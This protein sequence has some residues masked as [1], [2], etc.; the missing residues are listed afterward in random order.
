MSRNVFLVR[1]VIR[2][3]RGYTVPLFFTSAHAAIVPSWYADLSI[4]PTA[5]PSNI[6]RLME[7]RVSWRNT[8]K[9]GKGHKLQFHLTPAQELCSLEIPRIS[10]LPPLIFPIIG[11]VSLHDCQRSQVPCSCDTFLTQGWP[12]FRLVN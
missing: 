3:Q 4:H 12:L 5:Q 7:Q 2:L 6:L 1:T 8:E 11:M 9:V 10:S